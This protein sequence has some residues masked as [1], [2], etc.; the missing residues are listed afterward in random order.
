MVNLVYLAESTGG[1]YA[2]DV[3]KYPK[4]IDSAENF[5]SK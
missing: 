4:Q 5:C 2:I 1:S 3:D